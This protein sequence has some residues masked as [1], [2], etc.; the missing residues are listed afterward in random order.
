MKLPTVPEYRKKKARKEQ[1]KLQE[2]SIP[3]KA[4]IAEVVKKHGLDFIAVLEAGP[5][6]IY[7]KMRIIDV[8]EREK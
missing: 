2:R 1:Q 6:G 8:S 5:G 7:P 4:D 3:F